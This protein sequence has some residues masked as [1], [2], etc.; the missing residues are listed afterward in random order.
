VNGI[1]LVGLPTK[2]HGLDDN[3]AERWWCVLVTLEVI[4]INNGAVRFLVDSRL[5]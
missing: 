1:T 3:V 5:R 2:A 4:A